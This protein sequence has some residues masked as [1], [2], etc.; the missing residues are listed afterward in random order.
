MTRALL[1]PL[2]LM[3]A[4]A[5]RAK[6]A[7]FDMMVLQR[8]ARPVVSV[9]NLSV[10]GSGKTPLVIR[11]AQ[12][13]RERGFH[14]DVLSRGYGRRSTSVERVDP[15]GDAE[16]FG[17]EPLLITRAAKVPV[18][19]GASRFDAGRLAERE[20]GDLPDRLHLLDD[21]FQHRRLARAVDIVLVRRNDLIDRLLPAGRLREPLTSLK[22]ADVIVLREE[23]A[24]PATQLKDFCKEACY[25]W[26]VRRSVSQQPEGKRAFAFCAIAR[27]SEFFDALQASGT[28]LIERVSFR[29]HHCYTSR[30]IE[31]LAK[32]GSQRGCDEFV[33]TEKD[34][35]KLDEAMRRTL[36]AVAPLRV[37]TLSVE[38]VNESA[39]LD[40]LIGMLY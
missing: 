40:Q 34:S 36:S 24:L 4:S 29:D 7:R 30:D 2:E 23:D 14:P 3:Y 11:L 20:L 35:V 5:L 17:D 33:T 15:A 27:P 28:E 39:A 9:G 22:R 25:F 38:L 16:R 8:L 19:V 26:Q 6:N 37:Q 21:G 18:F 13:L 32:L 31:R 12:L 1:L 10:G